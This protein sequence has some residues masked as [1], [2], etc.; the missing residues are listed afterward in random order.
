MSVLPSPL[1]SPVTAFV[2]DHD[3]PPVDDA[4]AITGAANVT[5]PLPTKVKILVVA[6]P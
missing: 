5:S 4:Q 3:Q 2:F 1:K 6:P